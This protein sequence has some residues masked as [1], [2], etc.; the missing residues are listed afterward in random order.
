MYLL[1]LFLPFLGFIFPIL[2]GRF[3]GRGV[4]FIS[5]ASIGFTLFFT[6]ILFY[7][8]VYN[9]SIVYLDLGYWLNL[10][11]L[12]IGWSFLFD[13]ITVSMLFII[14]F[15]SFLVHFYSIYYM[16]TDK[17]YPRFMSYL[18]LFTFFMILLVTSNN[19]LLL[20]FGW[21]GVGLISYFLINFWYTRVLANKAALKAFIINKFG[22][23]FLLIGILSLVI[24]YGSLDLEIIF[25]LLLPNDDNFFIT[26][27]I[28]IGVM[29][30]SAQFGLHTWLPDAMEGPTPV[31]ALLHA[32]TMV[33]A[34]VYLLIRLS[35]IFS[36]VP[37]IL[38]LISIIGAL[39]AFFAASSG[40][41]QNDVKRVIAYST[42]SQLGYMVLA[43]GLLN[44]DLSFFHLINH[45]FFKALLFLSS[46]V[47]IHTFFNQ[48]DLR[49]MGGFLPF[50]PFVYS[51]FLI[52][53]L[54]LAGFPFLTGFYSK[55]LI[56][57]FAFSKFTFSSYFVFWLAL[58]TVSFTSFYSFRLLFFLFY[59]KPFSL[60]FSYYSHLHSSN[61][62][63]LFPL[64]LLALFSIF[65]GFLLKDLFVGLGSSFSH[66]PL[67]IDPELLP[68][69]FKLL[70]LFFSFGGFFFSYFIYF[71]FFPFLPFISFYSFF[72]YK[73]YFDV[74]FNRLAFNTLLFSY[75]FPLKSFDK[76]F[77]EWFG[78][79]G[80]TTIL[81]NHRFFWFSFHTGDIY[82]YSFFFFI[83]VIFLLLSF[84]FLTPSFA[85]FFFLFFLAFLLS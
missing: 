26:F 75:L 80:F 12:Q 57:E 35:P 39:T 22:D 70:P 52:G 30:K 53:S 14:S 81:N 31:S 63:A 74:L 21:E 66:F 1:I 49:F 25:S 79:K 72:S 62:F 42:S 41:V 37:S 56:L 69:H 55:D 50:L 4:F 51:L 59:H 65:F 15:I 10:T 28:L 67:D 3:L 78:S 9:F 16:Y 6:I 40:L 20:F 85:S 77:L 19:F 47:I 84:T 76:G 32:A 29:S 64:A 44:F 83:S 45:A 38:T 60:N 36:L 71:F 17:H 13:S 58:L 48:Q 68:L 8:V 73:W 33:T 2:F 7:E 27:M 23:I 54:S 34:G 43:C 61:F 46:G 5:T 82:N 18:S 11:H 24:Q